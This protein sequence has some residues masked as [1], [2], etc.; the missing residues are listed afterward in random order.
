MLHV[1]TLKQET[2]SNALM[3]PRFKIIYKKNYYWETEES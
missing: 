1:P 2:G 3:H